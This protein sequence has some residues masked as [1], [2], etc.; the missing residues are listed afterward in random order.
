MRNRFGV[1]NSVF[2]QF[3]RWLQ[4]RVFNHLLERMSD[5][6][7]FGYGLIDGTIVSADD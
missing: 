4:A 6:P 1:W 7:A 2:Q 3:R 5:G